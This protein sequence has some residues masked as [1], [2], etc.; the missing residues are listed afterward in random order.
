MRGIQNV[1][2]AFARGAAHKQDNEESI[3]LKLH[4]ER[5]GDQIDTLTLFSLMDES[6]L[7]SFFFSLFPKTKK[8]NLIKK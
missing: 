7:K 3:F 1:C 8:I 4:T 6:Q 5:Q 2:P